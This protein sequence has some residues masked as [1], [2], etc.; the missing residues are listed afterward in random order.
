M[1]SKTQ[2][3]DG[4]EVVRLGEVAEVVG[5]STPSRSRKEFWEGDVPWVVPSE[6]TNLKG[7]YLTATKEAI[8]D[9]GLQSAGLTLIPSGS[10][11]LTTR[12]T[13]GVTAINAIPVATNQGFQNL[14]PHFPYQPC[15]ACRNQQRNCPI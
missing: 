10:V 6:L 4:W 3:P 13:I 8:T 1:I 2:L 7:R 11:L 9:A 12:A 15:R 14:I 5:G